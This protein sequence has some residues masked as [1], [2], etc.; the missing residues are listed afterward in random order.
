MAKSRGL[1]EGWKNWEK[2]EGILSLVAGS[3]WV[4][5]VNLYVWRLINRPILS[6]FVYSFLYACLFLGSLISRGPE[7]QQPLSQ[8][9][10]VLLANCFLFLSNLSG[11]SLNLGLQKLSIG[12]PDAVSPYVLWFYGLLYIFILFQSKDSNFAESFPLWKW[13]QIYGSALLPPLHLS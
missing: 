11:C 1:W 3:P 9:N 2:H 10:H 4:P 5:E 6:Q 12:I 13:F 8:C 7:P